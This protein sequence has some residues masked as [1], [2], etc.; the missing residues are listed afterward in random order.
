MDSPDP[1]AATPEHCP[2]CASASGVVCA[3]SSAGSV[4]LLDVRLPGRVAWS[5][6]WLCAAGCAVL[7][8]VAWILA[9]ST[10]WYQA[11]GVF[12]IF[13]LTFAML[14]VWQ[15]RLNR[16]RMI[17][18][19]PLVH[20]THARA[21]YCRACECVYFNSR[22]LPAGIPVGTAMTIAEYRRRLWYACGFTKPI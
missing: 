5:G 4:K 13:A 16:S 3:A 6:L 22:K 14:G 19:E 8:V 1:A 10:G 11:A 18:A 2:S 15:T 17:G 9:P 7:G 20:K 21:L 12:V